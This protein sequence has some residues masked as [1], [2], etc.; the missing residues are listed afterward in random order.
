MDLL[1]ELQHA[2]FK[3]AFDEFDKVS[4]F[5]K[6]GKAISC[7]LCKTFSRP[8]S[9]LCALQQS[10]MT[11]LCNSIHWTADICSFVLFL[12]QVSLEF[13][14][15]KR[16]ISCRRGRRCLSGECLI[17]NSGVEMIWTND[18]ANL[19]RSSKQKSWITIELRSI[20]KS[21]QNVFFISSVY[22]K[23]KC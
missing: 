18:I 4:H 6:L 13:L 11:F 9:F 12:F 22:W 23:T 3:E 10:W 1:S 8:G 21:I 17:S 2:E 7:I 14:C 20:H 5:C 19:D 15:R 16:L